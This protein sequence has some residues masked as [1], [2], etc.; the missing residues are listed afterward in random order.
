MNFYFLLVANEKAFIKSDVNKVVKNEKNIPI[1]EA[2]QYSERMFDFSVKDLKTQHSITK[3]LIANEFLDIKYQGMGSNSIVYSAKCKRD[4]IALKMLKHRVNSYEG[5]KHEISREIEI[6]QKIRHPNIIEI[7]GS[8]ETPRKFIVLEQLTEGT[9]DQ[10][11]KEHQNLQRSRP[12]IKFG[13]PVLKVVSI[14]RDIASALK[15]LHYGLHNDA[16]IIHRGK[17]KSNEHKF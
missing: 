4:T 15:Y 13:L 6:L 8:G 5:A 12:D 3:N 9:L 16:T 2:I 11:L 1:V 10:M 17:L 14:C 7:K